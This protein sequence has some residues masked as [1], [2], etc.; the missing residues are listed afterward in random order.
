MNRI[1]LAFKKEGLDI[2]TSF[3]AA[4]IEKK[5]AGE[6]YEQIKTGTMS[7][8]ANLTIDEQLVNY[9]NWIIKF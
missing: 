1:R 3:V 7:F 4:A 9:C 6:I 5:M 8:A 2:A